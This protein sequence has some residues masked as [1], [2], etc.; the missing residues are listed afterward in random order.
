M[1]IRP[2]GGIGGGDLFISYN[3]KGIWSNAKNLGEP[4]NSPGTEYSPKISPDN[5]YFFF[6]STRTRQISLLKPSED[7]NQLLNRIYNAGN[8]LGDIYQIDIKQLQLLINN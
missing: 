3:K 8:G 7:Y 6:S 2:G 1:T 5:K 4:F